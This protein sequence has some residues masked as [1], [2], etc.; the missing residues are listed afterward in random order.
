MRDK[1]PD[2][3]VYWYGVMQRKYAYLLASIVRKKPGAVAVVRPRTVNGIQ[4]THVLLYGI[5][6]S[7]YER[8][9]GIFGRSVIN[10][11]DYSLRAGDEL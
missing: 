7:E 6:E 8:L 11:K 1:Q 4:E 5:S 10:L 3:E 2:Y 9:M